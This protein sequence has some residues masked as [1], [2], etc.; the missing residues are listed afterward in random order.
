MVKSPYY[1]L[2]QRIS[3][4]THAL[5]QRCATNT[6][7]PLLWALRE[8]TLLDYAYLGKNDQDILDRLIVE[9]LSM[10]NGR[11]LAISHMLNEQLIKLP[12]NALQDT[13]MDRVK[14]C[15]F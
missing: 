11:C 3:V 7:S 5:S 2:C 10:G 12:T 4:S 13:Y 6:G 8:M 14:R 9:C 1:D 15:P